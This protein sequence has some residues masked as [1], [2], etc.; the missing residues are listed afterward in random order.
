MKDFFFLLIQAAAIYFHKQNTFQPFASDFQ[1]LLF[2]FCI[3]VNEMSLVVFS[4][5]RI[6]YNLC[7]ISMFTVFDY[8]LR[9]IPPLCLVLL[10]WVSHIGA[11]CDVTNALRP[12]CLCRV[13]ARATHPARGLSHPLRLP[14]FCLVFVP[15]QTRGRFNKVST[16]TQHCCRMM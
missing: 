12:C 8:L 7:M 10:K 2:S 14:C 1:I 6:K 11:L 13:R 4:C 3:I 16:K 15:V 9:L 5:F